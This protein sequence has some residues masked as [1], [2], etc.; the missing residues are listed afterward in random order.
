MSLVVILAVPAS[1][2]SGTSTLD[3]SQF[4]KNGRVGEVTIMVKTRANLPFLRTLRSGNGRGKNIGNR[5]E[6]VSIK[7]E[8]LSPPV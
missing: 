2:T 3:N 8:F 5:E 6:N 7:S 1:V 4:V